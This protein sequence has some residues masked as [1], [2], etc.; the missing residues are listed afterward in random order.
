MG[1]A[2]PKKSWSFVVCFIF[3]FQHEKSYMFECSWKETYI[4]MLL[5]QITSQ[6]KKNWRDVPN[7]LREAKNWWLWAQMLNCCHI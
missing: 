7:E 3:C 2:E 5:S 6:I 4:Y 1:K